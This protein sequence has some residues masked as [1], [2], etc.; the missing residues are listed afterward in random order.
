MNK[1]EQT[2]QSILNEAARVASRIG[3]SGMTIG[4]LAEQAGMSKSGLFAHFKSKEA[5]QGE[6]LA[7]AS[8]VF[9]DRVMRPALAAPRGETRLRT[10]FDGWLK[11]CAGDALP[12]GCPMLA[13]VAELDDQPGVVREQLVRSQRDLMDS[14]AQMYRAAVSEGQFHDAADAEQFAHD[15]YGVMMAFSY[16]YRLLKDP[17][18][19]QRARRAFDNLLAAAR[20][21]HPVH[22]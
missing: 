2:R 8:A 4:S 11:W 14:L 3:L 10:L 15:F 1:G 6:T 18:A 21:Q 22:A 16:A 5:L 7:H 20:R 12:G 17:A 9:I 13:A 19:E